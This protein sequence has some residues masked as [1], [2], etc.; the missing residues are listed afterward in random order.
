MSCCHCEPDTFVDQ[1]VS[2][3]RV[4]LF[5]RLTAILVSA[6]IG[7]VVLAA[8]IAGSAPETPSLESF[9]RSLF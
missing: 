2:V 6:W 7:I 1:H 4:S 5:N 9:I 8:E 3:P